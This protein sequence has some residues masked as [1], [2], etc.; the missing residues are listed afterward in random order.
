MYVRVCMRVFVCVLR[1][2]VI[3]KGGGRDNGY[4][5]RYIDEKWGTRYCF[6]KYICQ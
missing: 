6:G 5:D 2:M 3:R 4:A 1:E